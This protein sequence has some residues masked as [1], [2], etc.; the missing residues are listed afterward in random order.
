MRHPTLIRE[1]QQQAFIGDVASIDVIDVGNA[2]DRK[3]A[4][5]AC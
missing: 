4:R 1:G 2:V 5:D 3:A